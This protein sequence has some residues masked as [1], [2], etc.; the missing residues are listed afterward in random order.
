[1]SG[2]GG[3]NGVRVKP[4]SYNDLNDNERWNIP[5]MTTTARALGHGSSRSHCYFTINFVP[6]LV[7]M[8]PRDA[9]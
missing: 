2:V 4:V 8:W 6:R 1:M 5:W 3:V 9:R 7:V